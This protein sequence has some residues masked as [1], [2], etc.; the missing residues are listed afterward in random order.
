VGTAYTSTADGNWTAAIWSPAGTPGNGDTVTINHTV[1][2]TT[3]VTVGHSPGAGDATNAIRIAATKALYVK[4]GGTLVCRGDLVM[5]GSGTVWIEPG[6]T[7]EFDASQAATPSTAAYKLSLGYGAGFITGNFPP[8]AGATATIRSN[9]GGAQAYIMQSGTLGG[10]A[11]CDTLFSRLG[12][13]SVA[14]M[15]I[16]SSINSGANMYFNRCTFDQYCGQL[17]VGTVHSGGHFEMNECNFDQTTGSLNV[18]GGYGVNCSLMLG[19]GP[20]AS[21]TR[22]IN[23]CYF[24]RAAIFVVP[25]TWAITRNIFMDLP[26]FTGSGSRWHSFENNF[27]RHTNGTTV[28]MLGG[29][30]DCY[31]LA[32]SPWADNPHWW[33]LATASHTAE[34]TFDGVVFDPFSITQASDSGEVLM[35]GNPPSAQTLNVKR[36]LLLPGENTVSGRSEKAC[37]GAMIWV[38]AAS[39]NLSLK[40]NHNTAFMSRPVSNAFVTSMVSMGENHTPAAGVVDEFRSNLAWG[41]AAGTAKL[42]LDNG[43][44]GS[45]ANTVTEGAASY[46][47]GYNLAAGYSSNPAGYD[48]ISSGSLPGT[49]D[50]IGDP[51]FV[52]PYRNIKTWATAKGLSG[53]TPTE[54]KDAA[55]AYLKADMTRLDDLLTHVRAG[56]APTNVAFQE[57]Y[58]TNVSGTSPTNGWIGAVEGSTSGPATTYTLTGPSSGTVNVASTNFTV[59]PNETFTG[60]ITP[61]ASAGSGTFTPSSLTWSGTSDA[62]TFTFTP[63]TLGARTISTTDD[64][65]L[66]DPASLVY[67]AITPPEPGANSSALWRKPPLAVLRFL[68]RRGG[69]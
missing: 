42:C 47:G 53:S 35:L 31:A 62:K 61:S 25:D 69:R 9:A 41:Y 50:V 58:E 5:A 32:D 18:G 67:T 45:V 14:A 68:L 6:G 13:S 55:I 4:P 24:N 10:A 27:V 51:A 40:V 34:T 63:S 20:V 15:D 23:K 28:G 39:P 7:L 38:G 36:C 26:V 56:A 12:S 43:K 22:P 3:A 52:A 57:D 2:V 19:V 17:Q 8:A 60:T 21:G 44:N 11:F 33:G 66:T 37:A 64:G 16:S 49:G 54:L 46:N 48:Y 65:G 30:K 59:T 1:N 29:A